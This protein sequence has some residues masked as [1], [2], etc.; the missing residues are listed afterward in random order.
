M[1]KRNL[2]ISFVVILVGI[3]L[4]I[5]VL[6]DDALAIEKALE[7]GVPNGD[8]IHIEHLNKNNALAFYKS[9]MNGAHF[10]HALVKKNIFGW[11]FMGA[12]SSDYGAYPS[13]MKLG[14]SWQNLEHEK[15]INYT[16][17]AQGKVLDDDIKEV[18]LM[19]EDGKEYSAEIIHYGGEDFWYLFSENKDLVTATTIGLSETGEVIFEY[20][21]S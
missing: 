7:A 9:E 19:T 20:P 3:Y 8:I 17:L 4:V 1:S 16:D 15:G 18:K 13:E 2:L 11:K 14:W 12:G 21:E 10:G 6:R 5:N